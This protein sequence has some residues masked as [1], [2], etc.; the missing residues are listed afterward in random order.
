M[1]HIIGD[2]QYPEPPA[3]GHLIMHEV[4]RPAGIGLGLGKNGTPG[5]DGPLA[6][7]ALAY[8]KAFLAVEPADAVDAGGLALPPEQ[9]EQPAVTEPAPRVGK[10]AQPYPQRRLRRAP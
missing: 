8:A 4:E 10:I 6:A 1:G 7:L 2:V 9:D 5:A 3:I